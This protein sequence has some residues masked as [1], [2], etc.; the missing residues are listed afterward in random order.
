MTA[1]ASCLVRD[2]RT[3]RPFEALGG[4]AEFACTGFVSAGFDRERP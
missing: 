2:I 4:I 3:I 1:I